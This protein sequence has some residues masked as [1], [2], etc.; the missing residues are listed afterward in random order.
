MALAKELVRVG[1][2]GTPVPML[3]PRAVIKASLDTAGKFGGGGGPSPPIISFI[4]VKEHSLQKSK[5][6]IKLFP[7]TKYY[8]VKLLNEMRSPRHVPSGYYEFLLIVKMR[9]SISIQKP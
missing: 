1:T 3:P 2:A 7:S 9:I 5:L 4:S 8:S 6:F